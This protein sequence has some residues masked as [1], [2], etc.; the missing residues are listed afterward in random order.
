MTDW[1]LIGVD[2]DKILQRLRDPALVPVG[3]KFFAGSRLDLQD[4]LTCLQTFDLL[5]LGSLALAVKRLRFGNR[6]FYVVNQ[7][8]NY[9]NVC[10]NACRFCAF[11]RAP[12]SAQGYLMT[13]E[14]ATERVAPAAQNGLKEV[15]VVG[16]INPEPE[17]SYYFELL[18]AL[19]MTA[20]RVGLKAFT[21]VEIDHIA[22]RAGVSWKECLTALK[23]AGLNALPGGG[24][25]VFS[26]RVRAELFPS[27]ISAETWL[28][29]HGTAHRLGIGSNATLLFG[30]IETHSER[31]EHLLKLRNQQD[32]TGGFRAFI[33]LAFQSRT[34][35]M[36]DKPGPTGVDIL[37]MMATSRLML[38]NIPH[39]KAYWVMLGRK[40]AQA[41][42]HFGADDVEGTIVNEQIA[43]EAGATTAVG[44][45]R[46]EVHELIS[47]AGAE[48]TER[49]T[50]HRGVGAA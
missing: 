12:G 30:H 33:P 14:E 11:H 22:N 29:V 45:S 49:D 9:T 7:H 19:K 4:G 35:L 32:E 50:F 18:Q 20:P 42:L 10:V 27:K 47:E 26:P 15:H 48:P 3:T 28:G 36:A 24:A 41:A 39:I 40:T 37:K 31:I 23:D 21:A 16:G 5:G 43:H 2:P 6:A 38:D 44:L 25:E 8:L 46:E 13:P 17:F 1:S 34:T